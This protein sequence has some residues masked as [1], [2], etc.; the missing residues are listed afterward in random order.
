MDKPSYFEHRKRLK[1][2]FAALPEAVPDAELLE[3][4]LGYVIRRRDVKPQAR[5]ILKQAGHLG[6]IFE[7]G[8]AAVK[9]IGEETET[10][11][12]LLKEFMSRS[13]YRKIEKKPLTLSNQEDVYN[14]LKCRMA[15]T[16]QEMLI[17]LFLDA[18][19]RLMDNKLLKQGKV[20]DIAFDIRD[21]IALSLERKAHGVILAHNHPTGDVQPTPEDTAST[22]EVFKALGYAGVELV[23]HLIVASTGYYSMR[24]GGE[25]QRIAED[26]KK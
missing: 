20:G 26:I 25:L 1:E 2:R 12:K 8:L 11:F 6:N 14:Y 10:F 16:S 21:I 23:D 19:N 18:K 9:G 22:R 5:D 3:L 15:D 7:C 24:G 17:V 13:L 4:L